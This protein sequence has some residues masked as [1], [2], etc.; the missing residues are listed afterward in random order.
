METATSFGGPFI[1]L[2]KKLADEWSKAIGDDPRPDSGLYGEVCQF[3]SFMHPISFGGVTVVRIGDE[4]SDLFWV[5]SNDGGL[6]LQW[7]GADSLDDL[8]SFGQRVAD[9]DDWQETLEL[10]LSE[11][12]IRIMDSCGFEGDNQPKIDASL[13]PG[14]Y[15]ID[16]AY[17]EDENTMATVFRLTKNEQANKPWKID[18]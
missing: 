9:G 1:L 16:A 14:K 10:T 17:A 11:G 2:P 8:V 13:S 4:P 5:P 6:I 7:V 18:A 15:R 12:E 3:G